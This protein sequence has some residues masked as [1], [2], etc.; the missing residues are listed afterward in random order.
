MTFGMYIRSCMCESLYSHI[1][2]LL[3]TFLAARAATCVLL[4]QPTDSIHLTAHCRQSQAC[5]FVIVLLV[6]HS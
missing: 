4:P 5:D 2:N 6:F 1:P 3:R